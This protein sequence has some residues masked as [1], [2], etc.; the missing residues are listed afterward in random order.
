VRLP[1]GDSPVPT[2]TSHCFYSD[3]TFG[4]PVAL[5]PFVHCERHDLKGLLKLG[6]NIM[7]KLINTFAGAILA[8]VFAL[9]LSAGAAPSFNEVDLDTDGR[10]TVT[11]LGSTY[12]GGL[13][14]TTFSYSVT[15]LDDPALSH[16]N[17]GFPLCDQLTVASWEPM[18]AVSIGLDP[19]TGVYGIKWDDGQDT[20]TTRTYSVTFQG[21]IPEGTVEVAV[22]AGL[23]V[24][25]GERPGPACHFLESGDKYDISGTVF[26]DADLDGVLDAGEPLIPNVT[27][28]L[29][30]ENGGIVSTTITDMNG[31]YVFTEL[32]PG[33]Y[34]VSVPV[35]TAETDFNE[36]LA[37]FF[38]PTT[39]NLIEVELV[40]SDSTGN[41][42]GFAIDTDTLIFT[43][44]GKTIGFWKH[45]LSVAIQGKGKAQVAAPTMAGYIAQIEALYLVHPFQFGGSFA[46]ALS[47]LSSTSPAAV[48]LLAKQLL[49]TE[50]NEVAG[51]GLSPEFD[52]LQGILIAWGE[53]LV[54]NWTAFTRDQLLQAKDVFDA[55]NNTGN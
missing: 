49:G 42:F 14:Q 34:V 23:F 27:V 18:G 41:D 20:G 47:V 3:S 51:I 52:Q 53:Y 12:D 8:L 22:K 31:Y 2:P 21:A 33:S 19:T 43:G 44:N 55:I 40:D 9:P 48:D 24:A 26:V 46:A 4:T 11:Y 17:V 7:K 38:F 25:I 35:E 1:P 50:F 32:N 13:N 10:W 15:V 28:E 5:K 29:A 16:F 36:Q 37:Q 6:E 39:P 54:A 45:Q 30:D